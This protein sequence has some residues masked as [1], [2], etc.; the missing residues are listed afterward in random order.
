MAREIRT[1][2][3]AFF[4]DEKL[5][6]LPREVRLTYMGLIPNADDYGRLQGDPRLVKAAVYPLDEGMTAAQLDAELD[7]LVAAGRIKRYRVDGTIYLQI[8][9]FGKHQKMARMYA[10]DIPEPPPVGE[11]EPR[12]THAVRTQCADD[13]G[14]VREQGADGAQDGGAQCSRTVGAETKEKETK[15]RSGAE[16]RARPALTLA[17]DPDPLG[18]DQPPA[19]PAPRVAL[20]PGAKRLLEEMYGLAT[21]KRRDDVTRQLFDALDFEG[22]GARLRQGIR[23]HARSVEHMNEVCLA[24]L[25][26]PPR[27]V[28]AAVVIVLEKLRDPPP[29][30]TATEIASAHA[31]ESMAVEEEYHE[32]LRAAGLAWAKAHP[33]EFANLRKPIDAEYGTEPVGFIKMTRDAKLAQATA[34]AC[35]FPSFD[36]WEKADR[37]RRTKGRGVA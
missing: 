21:K 32:A 9:N 30:P 25:S 2:K 13:A 3:R 14:E 6:E 22:K 28:D 16:V 19:P 24:V 26:D 23:V 1:L 33:E 8:V 18:I 12:T 4:H 20:P 29:G 11:D 17:A 27:N 15:E 36:E 35:G 7:Q 5:A 31:A 37:T 10:S 34:Q